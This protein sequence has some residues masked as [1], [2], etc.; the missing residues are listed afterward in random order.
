[1]RLSFLWKYSLGTLFVL[2]SGL[3]AQTV[4]YKD[5]TLTPEERTLDLLQRMTLEEKVGQLLC[6]LGWEMYAGRGEEVSYSDAYKELLDERHAGMLWAMFRA[7]P[8]TKKTLANGL[9]PESAARAANALQRHAVEETRL[10]IPVFLAE[11]AAHGHMAIGTTVFPTGIGQAATFNPELI[12]RMG[13]VIGEE[14]R[15]QGAHIGYGPVLDLAREP[16]WSRVEETYGEDP[17]L[18]AAMGSAFVL[19]MGGGD[20]SRPDAVISTLK[21]FVAYGVPEGG[22]NGNPSVAGERDLQENFLLPFRVAVDAGALSVMTAYNSM[23]GIPCTMNAHLLRDILRGEWGFRGFSVSDLYSIDGIWESHRVART[24]DE[25]GALALE[26]GLDVD[27]GGK[28]FGTLVASV[29]AGRVPE[30]LVDSAAARVLRLKFEMG[31]FD[32]PYVDPQEAKERVRSAEHVAVAREVARQ[33]IVLL[34]NRDGLLPLDE[35]KIKRMAV[36]GPN[37]DNLY[38]MLG[39]YTAP[40]EPDNVS[41]VYEALREALGA[42]RVVYAKGCAVRDVDEADIDEAVRAARSS[43]VAVVVVGGS[44]ARDFRTN[45]QETGAAIASED[46]VSDM[47]CGEGFDRATLSL[48]G[49]QQELLEAV[50]AT[51]VPMVV[52]YI[53][54]RPLDMAWAKDEADA[55]LTAWYPGQEGGRAVAD[56]LLGR[57]NP[58]GRLPVSVPRHVG[59]LPVYYNK[60]NPVGHDYVEMGEAPLYAFGYGKGFSPFSYA[61]LSVEQSGEQTFRVSFD[62]KNE[63]RYDGTEVA[64]LYL[65]DEYASVVRPRLQLRRFERIFLKAGEVRRVSFDLDADDFSLINARMERVVEPGAFTVM[66]GAASDDIRLRQAVE[67]E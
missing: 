58:G 62:V 47:E 51:G 41:T 49:R 29:R 57:Y 27:L 16:R 44:S 15:L 67:V 30:A 46:Y 7:D 32:R 25:A 24:L 13:R 35:E 39:D 3:S 4:P 26:A 28:A 60:K 56:V 1:M 38:N 6:P 54:G 21:H 11:E 55:L 2:S 45:Y 37:A 14:L 33:S 36:I 5:A 19:G 20:L 9:D 40:Q 23:D 31:L 59:Q 43:D 64:Q 53:Q 65:R 50:R 22:H 48:L 12:E 34:E 18:S 63:G 52:V 42:D 10:G 66:V 17:V 8:W 61:N